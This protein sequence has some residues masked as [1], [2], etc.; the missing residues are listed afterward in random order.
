[1]KCLSNFKRENVLNAPTC[2]IIKSRIISQS[3]YK[4]AFK[5]SQV[6]Y[7]VKH[8]LTKTEVQGSLILGISDE[9]RNMFTAIFLFRAARTDKKHST[10][11]GQQTLRKY[12]NSLIV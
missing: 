5:L 9:N 8:I 1:M 4:N 7:M 3:G 10:V 11:R 12:S 2:R 6:V